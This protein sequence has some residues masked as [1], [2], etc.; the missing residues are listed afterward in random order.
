[1]NGSLRGDRGGRTG[2]QVLLAVALTF[3]LGGCALMSK[4]FPAPSA[5]VI[6]S[7]E[8]VTARIEELES[9][10]RKDKNADPEGALA[11]ELALLYVHP[12]NPAPD[13]GRSLAMLRAYLSLAPPG[14]EDL[15]TGRLA[16][17]LEVIERLGRLLRD[18]ETQEDVLSAQEQA[19]LEDIEH[20]GRLLR[21]S[22]TQ[23]YVL[24]GQV[25]ALQ[26]GER[27]AKKREQELR[28]QIKTLQERIEKIQALELEMEQRRRPVR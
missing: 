8:Q 6:A 14:E 9:Q 2:G 27:D 24:S 5:P 4:L 12:A 22:K 13:Y 21:D 10:F 11:H 3:L 1:M 15:E 16:A 28:A 23:E 18:S 25:Q 20:L 26:H 19:L 17:L 7:S